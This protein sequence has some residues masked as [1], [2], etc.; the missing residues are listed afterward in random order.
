MHRTTRKWPRT[1]KGA[2]QRRDRELI[3]LNKEINALPVVARELAER[4]C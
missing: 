2:L 1:L 4:S 3:K